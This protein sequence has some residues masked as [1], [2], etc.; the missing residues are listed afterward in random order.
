V[1]LAATGDD[2]LRVDPDS[3]RLEATIRI[4]ETLGGR[5][6][7]VGGGAAFAEGRVWAT[8]DSNRPRGD[9][10][11]VDPSTNKP[12]GTPITVGSGPDAIVRG[13]G[14]LWVENTSTIVGDNA[15]SQIY[16]TM[17]RI[18][19]STRRTTNEHFAGIPAIGFGSLWVLSDAGDNDAMV[20]R[21]NPNTGQ[22][23]A[24]IP[25]PRVI[26]LAFG[27]RRVWAICDPTSRSS[28]TFQP[29]RGTAAL[30][31]LDPQT[32]HETGTPIHLP[33]LQPMSIV[34]SQDQLWIADY[35]SSEITH[36]RLIKH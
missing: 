26:A 2:L 1:W 31:Q 9:V 15:P 36:F 23:I 18:D 10:I 3:N 24:R 34:V 30:R 8:R 25:M 12:I 4:G 33:T 27:G 6:I 16:P 7:S 21:V 35:R 5:T 14:S 17:S 22:P 28:R 32:D 19:P 13:F 20:L 29:I 11:V